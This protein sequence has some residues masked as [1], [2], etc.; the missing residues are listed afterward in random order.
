MLDQL[1]ATSYQLPVKRNQ[2]PSRGL[3]IVRA[4]V[5]VGLSTSDFVTPNFWHANRDYLQ[6]ILDRAAQSFRRAMR[7]CHP[8]MTP[9]GKTRTLNLTS[10]WAVVRQQFARHLARRQVCPRCSTPFTARLNK[11]QK[12]CT[13]PCARKARQLDTYGQTTER[14]AS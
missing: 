3:P 13:T 7:D 11:R 2:S 1:P 14:A 12:Y 4:L 6:A 8:D 10:A 5:T 9:R